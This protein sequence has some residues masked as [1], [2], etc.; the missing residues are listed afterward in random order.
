MK[1]HHPDNSNI[2]DKKATEFTQELNSSFDYI[3]E[4]YQRNINIFEFNLETYFT[5][6]K[7]SLKKVKNFTDYFKH[8]RNL[9]FDKEHLEEIL[10]QEFELSKDYYN[11]LLTK[12]KSLALWA[13]GKLAVTTG[14][15][16]GT[17][18]LT[19]L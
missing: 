4:A 2:I 1:I 19:V 14:G 5:S 9:N 10:M 8:L 18:P 13:T 15:I 6:Q 17:Y 3:K 11:M 16:Y 12:G 7:E